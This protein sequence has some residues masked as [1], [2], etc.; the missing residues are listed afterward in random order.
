MLEIH[1]IG[2]ARPRSGRKT[3]TPTFVRALV[4]MEVLLWVVGE[5]GVEPTHRTSRTSSGKSNR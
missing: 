5:V 4:F 1:K 3:N 2:R